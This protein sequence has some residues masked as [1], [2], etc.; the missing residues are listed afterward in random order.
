VADLGSE[1]R[2]LPDVVFCKAVY[3]EMGQKLTDEMKSNGK[4][5]LAEVRDLF[6]SSRKYAM[7]L[8]EP[9]DEKKTTR[10]LGDERPLR[11]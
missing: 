8:L 1:V 6:H 4:I 2:V 11:N 9:P 10:R 3:N 5:T 7:A